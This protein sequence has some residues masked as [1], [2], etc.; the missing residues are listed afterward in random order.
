MSGSNRTIVEDVGGLLGHLADVLP[1]LNGKTILITGGQGFLLS[2]LV[3][4][5]VAH[6]DVSGSPCRIVVVDNMI[7]AHEG[8]LSHLRGRG[9][10]VFVSHNIAQPLAIDDPVDYAVHGASIASPLVY[11]RFPLET[12]TANVDGTR[13]VLDLARDRGAKGVVIMSSSEIYGDPDPAFIPTPEGYRGQVSCTGPRA[14]YDES[15]R[16][17]ETLAMTFFRLYDLPVKIIR[18]FN[19]FGPGQ[20]LD[21]GRIIPDMM[22]NALEGGPLVLHGDGRSTRSFCYISDATEAIVRVLLDAPAGEAF[23]VG[24]DEAEITI[25]DLARMIAEIAGPG[26]QVEHRVSSDPN[27]LAD[28]PQRRCPDLTKIRETLGWRPRVGLADGLSRCLRSYA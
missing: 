5:L 10:V 8:R 6:N 28:N 3:D 2:Y 9:D 22:R 16:L 20:R 19:V 27:Y 4:L 23:N 26:V 1:Q 7:T 12:I 14:C 25:G 21:D 11:R 24:N 18:P 13:N 15:K 17:A